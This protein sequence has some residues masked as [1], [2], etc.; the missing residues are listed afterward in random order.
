M[1]AIS[2]QL[3]IFSLL[4]LPISLVACDGGISN[5]NNDITLTQAGSINLALPSDPL[6]R[7]T[8]RALAS[9]VSAEINI[10]PNDDFD[11]D[12]FNSSP[13]FTTTTTVDV[14]SIQ[15]LPN[16]PFTLSVIWTDNSSGVPV[17][18][19]DRPFFESVATGA[20]ITVT[21]DEYFTDFDDDGDDL[22]N[23]QEVNQGSDPTN[24]NSPAIQDS[25]DN[26][27]LGTINTFGDVLASN[28]CALDFEGDVDSFQ[29]QLNAPGVY[30]NIFHQIEVG[31]LTDTEGTL[32]GPAGEF[33]ASNDDSAIGS[34]PF[35]IEGVGN[36]Q[37]IFLE[38]GIYTV[39]V[40]ASTLAPSSVGSYLV[41]IESF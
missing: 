30:L 14:V 36:A 29:F 12:G 21:Q 5:P 24:F 22:T 28:V 35:R 10:I 40:S 41:L 6:T 27:F 32:F 33:I 8:P 17:A 20:T 23:L 16:G 9:Q 34:L 11:P 18:L 19:L 3:H 13:N 15:F 37:P 4:V 7:R 1:T 25:C 38:T 26:E 39:T 2:R 31:M